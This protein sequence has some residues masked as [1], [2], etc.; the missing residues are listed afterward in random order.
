MSDNAYTFHPI[1]KSLN[2]LPAARLGRE[3]IQA[4][5]TLDDGSALCQQTPLER[6]AITWTE[7]AIDNIIVIDPQTRFQRMLG[8]GGT[9]LDSDTY[10]LLRLTPTDRAEAIAAL[11]SPDNGL[12]FN[13]MRIPFGSTDWNRDWDF[14]TYCDQKDPALAAFSI[15]R[16]I[17]R[18]QIGIIKAFLQ[19][20][21][22]IKLL[23][24]VWGLPAWMKTNGKIIHGLF[25]S[26]YTDIYAEYLVRCLEAYAQQ[27]IPIDYIT[28]QNEPGT[29]DDRNTPATMW[30]WQQQRDITLALHQRLAARK[31]PTKIWGFDHNFDMAQSY[32]KPMLDDARYKDAI[33][34]VAFHDYRGHPEEMSLLHWQHPDVPVVLTERGRHDLG[35]ML[36]MMECFRHWAT[37]HISW[38]TVCNDQGG[39]HQYSG[40]HEKRARAWNPSR[41][42]HILTVPAVEPA[43][44]VKTLIYYYY[45]HFTRFIARGAVRVATN[46]L[47]IEHVNNIAW[48]NPDGSL[49]VI[50]GNNSDKGHDLAV[51]VQAAALLFHLPGKSMVTLKLPPV[52]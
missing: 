6:L 2:L 34:A 11:V 32:V 3:H 46:P 37:G 44:Y 52:S 9:I 12:G 29:A 15:Q 13:L 23:A 49:I 4:W 45:A 17:E 10:N 42:G 40:G 24:S 39:P 1:S 50:I 14:Y 41:S 27:G 8:I 36:R 38:T 25:D 33:E 19:A 20:N 51:Q 30:H 7:A 5:L 48:Q 43:R 22:Q 28:S 16:D 35:A 47:A 26:A 31:L 21:P 18:G